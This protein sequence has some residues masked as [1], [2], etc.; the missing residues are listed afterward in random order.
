MSLWD[1]DRGLVAYA[2]Q[3]MYL[4]FPD[5]PPSPDQRRPRL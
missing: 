1:P 3:V 4:L 2:T 5:G